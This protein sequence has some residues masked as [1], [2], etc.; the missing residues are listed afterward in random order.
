MHKMRKTAANLY[1]KENPLP[2]KI[3]VQTNQNP[4]VPQERKMIGS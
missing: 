1:D 2:L 4:A 3:I